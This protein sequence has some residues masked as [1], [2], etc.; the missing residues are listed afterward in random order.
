M[1]EFEAQVV[2]CWVVSERSNV[3]ERHHDQGSL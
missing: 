2:E 1:A 3:V